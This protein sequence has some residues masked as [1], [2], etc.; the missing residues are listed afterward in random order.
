MKNPNRRTL[1]ITLAAAALV[2]STIAITAPAQASDN[3][4]EVAALVEQV[5]PAVEG[6]DLTATATAFTATDAA[7]SV[8]IPKDSDAE[9]T[10]NPTANSAPDVTVALPVEANVADARTAVDGT[11]VYPS[12]DGKTSDAVQATADGVRLQTVSTGAAAGTTFT[13]NFGSGT[14]LVANS[15]GSVDV[16]S[17]S[18]NGVSASANVAPA[19]AYDA[20]GAAVP[21]HYTV[22]GATL[23]Q[24]ISPTPSTVYPVV[25]DPTL[26]FGWNIYWT[27]SQS[28]QRILAAGGAGAIA[29]AACEASVGFGCVA[30][31]AAAAAG[32]A[33]INERGGICTGSRPRMQIAI[34][35][36]WTGGPGITMKCIA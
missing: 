12:T 3:T 36:G 29:A 1:T 26:S 22:Q 18:G 15:D 32:V 35:W 8:S 30:A 31:G 25:A 21:T 28:D 27:F 23:V 33:W 24:T 19:W 34:P 20:T 16:L 4:G 5:A 14:S 9:V 17:A 10:I 7:A 11:V 2:V 13:Y 6:A